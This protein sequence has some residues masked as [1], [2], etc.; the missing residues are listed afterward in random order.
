MTAPDVLLV[1]A[2]YLLLFSREEGF[3]LLLLVLYLIW[4]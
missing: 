1:V 3:G 2:L 4:F